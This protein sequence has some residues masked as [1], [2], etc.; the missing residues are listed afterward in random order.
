MD[1]KNVTTHLTINQLSP[2]DKPREKLLANGKKSLSDAELIAILLGSGTQ[3]NNAVELAQKILS[4]SDN[5]LLT[6][7]Q[8]K[9]SDFMK[10]K[11]IGTVKAITLL[12]AFELGRR[13]AAEEKPQNTTYILDSKD[14]YNVVHDKIEDLPHE[15]FYAVYL[16]S[17]GKV[18]YK[19]QISLGGL[20]S[21]H[22]DLR[23]LFHHAIEHN[24]VSIAVAHNH[25][26][27]SLTPSK[28]DKDLTRRI[29]EAGSIL[30]IRLL[31]HIIV[32]FAPNGRGDYFSFNDNGLL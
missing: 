30:G 20:A 24:A 17:R 13:M 18:L 1:S 14:L 32:A 26:S 9:A 12:A 28:D 11:G 8:R 23:V 7:T 10:L 5:S 15:E 19:T 4:D 2:A 27:G 6:L 31:D 29:K 22:V 25:P 21:V 3:G 16:N